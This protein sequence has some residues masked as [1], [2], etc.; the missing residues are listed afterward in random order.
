[1]RVWSA[2]ELPEA[3]ESAV[4][5]GAAG[6]FS[7]DT[8]MLGRN[9]AQIVDLAQRHGLLAISQFREFAAEGGLMAY[10]PNLP[11]LNRRAAYYVDRILNGTS[12]AELPVEQPREFDFAINLKTAQALG[13]T[14]PNHVLLQAT[15]VI[16]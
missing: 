6:L 13:L 11:A 7:I 9:R 16:Q 5:A 3:F 12:P 10:G 8:P 1:M 2:D 15:E 14:I 4:Q